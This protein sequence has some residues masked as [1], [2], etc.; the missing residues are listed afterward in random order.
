MLSLNVI[1]QVKR[2]PFFA[3]LNWHRLEKKLIQAPYVPAIG[4]PTDTSNFELDGEGTPRNE[5]KAANHAGTA[6]LFDEF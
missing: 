1:L 4:S 5:H 2:E 3:K 6:H